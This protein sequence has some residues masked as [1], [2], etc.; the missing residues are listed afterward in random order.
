MAA[1]FL[2]MAALAAYAGRVGTAIL[3]IRRTAM[4]ARTMPAA[5]RAGLLRRAIQADSIVSAA[6]GAVVAAGAQPLG[7]ALGIPSAALLVVGLAFLPYAAWL[8][9]VAS[10]PQI[11]RRAAWVGLWLNVLWIVESLALLV[12]GW[13]PLTQVGWWTVLIQALLLA[14]ITEAQYLGLRQTKG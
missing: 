3:P 5:G 9:Y 8:W 11:S 14:A 13:L 12:S 7:A 4:T 10:R 2:D 1:H 6:S